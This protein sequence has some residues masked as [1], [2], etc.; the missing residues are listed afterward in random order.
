MTLSVG[1]I[2]VHKPKAVIDDLF[3]SYIVNPK[4][5]DIQLYWK[6]DRGEILKNF[7]NLKTHIES[8]SKTL[9]FAM[10]AGM[11][12]K[13]YSPQGLFVQN[14]K[15]LTPL[16]T[17][18]GDGNFYLKPN[19]IFYITTN[20]IGVVCETKNYV[21]NETIKFATQ[22]GPMLVIDGAIHSVLKKGS[23]NLN[24]RNGVGI[25]PN[26]NILFVM[27]KT[28]LNFYDFANYFKT[29]GCK[30]ALYLDGFVSRVYLPEKKW[31]QL[32]GDFGVMIG[33]TSKVKNK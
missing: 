3:L 27:S 25:L 28:K 9:V 17:N 5:Q 4:M 11:F 12:T 29:K 10:N 33:V 30:Y 13:E 24:I 15:T 26:N 7:K 31:E 21:S 16:D 32:D 14:N 22:S 23:L 18:S 2:S 6:N 8:K 1:L 20:N 19:G